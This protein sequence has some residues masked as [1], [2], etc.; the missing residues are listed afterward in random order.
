MWPPERVGNI[1]PVTPGPAEPPSPPRGCG[2]RRARAV[3]RVGSVIYKM[4]VFGGRWRIR[5]IAVALV[6]AATA[7]VSALPALATWTLMFAI[8]AGVAVAE[9][10]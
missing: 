10:A 1:D 5:A 4:R 2:W 6:A 9:G 3:S 8:L 7:T